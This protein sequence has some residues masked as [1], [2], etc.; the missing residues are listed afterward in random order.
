[1]P[2]APEQQG[3]PKLDLAAEVL[4]SGGTVRLKAWG[5]SM[6]PTLW[7]GDLLTIENANPAE[8]APGEIVLLRRDHRFFVHRLAEKR[9]DQG[10]VHWVTRGDAVGKKDPPAVESELLGRVSGIERSHHVR[11][12][13]GRLSLFNSAVAWMLCRSKTFRSVALRMHSLRLFASA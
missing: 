5:T 6:L 9:M 4:R 10:A 7:P 11:V 8:I 3:D 12:P 2:T 13:I 1:M